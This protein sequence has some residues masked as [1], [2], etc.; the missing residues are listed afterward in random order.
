MH[1]SC[2]KRG[3]LNCDT[4]AAVRVRALDDHPQQDLVSPY[5]VVSGI[6][7]A[8]QLLVFV[9]ARSR[10]RR[11]RSRGGRGRGRTRAVERVD[12]VQ[13]VRATQESRVA[14]AAEK[15]GGRR[16]RGGR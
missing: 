6:F 2:Q 10:G 13:G 1:A 8:A 3:T 14:G 9:I 15:A 7:D 16:G 11:G 12:G 4:P 5:P